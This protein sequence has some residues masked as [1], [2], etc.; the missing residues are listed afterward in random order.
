[1]RYNSRSRT[2][3]EYAM[4]VLTQFGFGTVI[5]PPQFRATRRVRLDQ[6]FLGEK[7]QNIPHYEVYPYTP[8]GVLRTLHVDGVGLVSNLQ[9]LPEK[10]DPR[11]Y[12]EKL[13]AP[14]NETHIL[15]NTEDGTAYSTNALGFATEDF[16][17]ARPFIDRWSRDGSPFDVE[18][19]DDKAEAHASF[20]KSMEFSLGS[21]GISAH[22][23]FATNEGKVLRFCIAVLPP[24][25][26]ILNWRHP[27]LQPVLAGPA[28][29]TT[30]TGEGSE[31]PVT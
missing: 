13:R 11:L 25:G 23:L 8:W 30:P 22:L 27:E 20:D 10:P 3:Q 28:R 14:A 9:F 26:T 4:R 16:L 29:G 17:V 18:M 1:M 31:F 19:Y 15:F 2:P 24:Q 7:D 6:A 12:E 5:S 21:V